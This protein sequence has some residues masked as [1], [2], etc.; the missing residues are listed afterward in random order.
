MPSVTIGTTT[1]FLNGNAASSEI[2]HSATGDLT[3]HGDGAWSY[4][5]VDNTLTHEDNDPGGK[6]HTD[7]DSDRGTGDQV[8]DVFN[9]TVT[10]ADGDSVASNLVININDDAPVS[11]GAENVVIANASGEP[12]PQVTDLIVTLD[13]SGSMAGAKLA[14]GI[15]AMKAL[16]HQYDENGGVHV[17]FTTFGT[18]SGPSTAWMT[19]T[20]A[21]AFLDDLHV[22][23]GATSI[24]TTKPQFTTPY[25]ATAMMRVS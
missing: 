21:Q 22:F 3:I 2:F 23:M 9:L 10:D 25:W 14:S 13:T 4:T 6:D 17:Q 18:N 20:Q 12:I 8:Q 16:I 15:E 11:T 19:E 5:M 1:F 24:R 7:G